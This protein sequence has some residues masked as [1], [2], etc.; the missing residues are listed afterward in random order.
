VGNKLLPSIGHISI[1]GVVN[2]SGKMGY[3]DLQSTPLSIVMKLSKI[4]GRAVENVVNT[5]L[6]EKKQIAY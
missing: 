6:L 1:I 3:L 5:T 2:A 4:I